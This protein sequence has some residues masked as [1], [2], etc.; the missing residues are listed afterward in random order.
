MFQ[1]IIEVYERRITQ[2]EWLK[3]SEQYSWKEV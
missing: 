2:W 1:C 3:K